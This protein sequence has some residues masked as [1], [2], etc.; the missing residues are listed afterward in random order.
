MLYKMADSEFTGKAWFNSSASEHFLIIFKH[1]HLRPGTGPEDFLPHSEY[2]S[3]FSEH[4]QNYCKR[5][6]FYSQSCSRN[7]RSNTPTTRLEK[8]A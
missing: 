3:M 7:K 6:V 2:S 4:S 1:L 8:P 5:Y